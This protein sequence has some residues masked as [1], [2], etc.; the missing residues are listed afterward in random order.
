MHVYMNVSVLTR[1]LANGDAC[2]KIFSSKCL[3]GVAKLSKVCHKW[4]IKHV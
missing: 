2:I 1:G 4:P 3:V